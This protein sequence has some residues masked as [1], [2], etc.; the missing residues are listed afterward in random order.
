MQLSATRCDHQIK[1][2]E[3]NSVGSHVGH[4]SLA[5][6]AQRDKHFFTSLLPDHRPFTLEMIA[7]SC[8]LFFIAAAM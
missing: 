8:C 3:K 2:V 7:H 6:M 4:A 1:E 5:Q